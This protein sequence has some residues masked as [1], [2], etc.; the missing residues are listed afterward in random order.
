MPKEKNQ[1]YI[2]TKRKLSSTR[3]I[4]T[5]KR[6]KPRQYHSR[7]QIYLSTQHPSLFLETVPFLLHVVQLN[8]SASPSHRSLQDAHKTWPVTVPHSLSHSGHLTKTETIN[9]PSKKMLHKIWN[10]VL[11]FDSY[12]VG[13]EL[14]AT[15][16]PSL[17]RTQ[18]EAE[19]RDGGRGGE[20]TPSF[21]VPNLTEATPKHPFNLLFL[22]TKFSPLSSLSQFELVYVI[23]NYRNH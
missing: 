2:S 17:W 8:H 12:T 11:P 4:A 1:N 19:S 22:H 7:Y 20:L 18:G 15:M 21:E 3:T 5:W 14:R 13:Y 23:D 10:G 16:S 9:F 6:N